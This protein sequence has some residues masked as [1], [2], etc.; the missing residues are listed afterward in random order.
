[1]K[2]KP[3]ESLKFQLVRREIFVSYETKISPGQLLRQDFEEEDKDVCYRLFVSQRALHLAAVSEIAEPL[4][5]FFLR[6]IG[7]SF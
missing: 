4:M 1:M 5:P 6:H 7:E 2:L 3:Q